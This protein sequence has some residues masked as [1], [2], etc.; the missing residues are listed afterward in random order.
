MPKE[1]QSFPFQAM[2]SACEL[3]LVGPEPLDDLAR[4]A[5]AAISEVQR[6]EHKYSRYR[7]DSI[8]SRINQAA[9][10]QAV[11]CDDETWNLFSY[12]DQLFQLSE[13]LFDI[14]AGVL[15]KAWNF[16]QPF[17]PSASQVEQLCQLI[18]W[19]SCQR[20]QH[21]FYL[22][23][24]GMEIDFGGF[25]KEY[26]ADRAAMILESFG[27]QHG[28]V[29]LGGDIRFLGP[30]LD[31]SSWNIGI[32]HPRQRHQL[33][34]SIPLQ[35][36]GLATSGDYEKYFELNG[37]RYCHVLNPK[38]GMPVQYWASISVVAPNS[39]M[40]GSYSTIAMLF[41]ER[42]IDFLQAS[43]LKYFAINSNLEIQY[44]Q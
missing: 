14:T 18:D 16:K 32:Q 42:A 33:V 1:I 25:G 23:V 7:V 35:Q 31:G 9:G 22:P 29:N 6:I 20:D 2:G 37:K 39:I 28:Y 21:Q 15:R 19:K 8:V 13:G 11:D 36:G 38:T 3:V 43:E 4:M 26:A 40:A 24:A 41:E 5:G 30:K 34:A 44:K 10:H 17:L 27:L 12:A